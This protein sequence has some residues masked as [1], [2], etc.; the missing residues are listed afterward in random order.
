[1]QQAQVR[2]ADVIIWRKTKKKRKK[3]APF[4]ALRIYNML[5]TL[6]GLNTREKISTRVHPAVDL[7]CKFKYLIC[8]FFS[9]TY[10]FTVKSEE[11]NAQ[12]V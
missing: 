6:V 1:M 8:L 10:I 2:I 12:D 9:E 11:Q 4:W 3:V 5:T 7:R